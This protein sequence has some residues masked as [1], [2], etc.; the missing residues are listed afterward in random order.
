MAPW[1]FHQL[2]P[3]LL[4]CLGLFRGTHVYTVIR[5]LEFYN[6]DKVD[7]MMVEKSG[8]LKELLL[9]VEI[10]GFLCLFCFFS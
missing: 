6:V 3:F 10:S 7:A 5:A 1:L 4:Q 9:G 2:L 8:V